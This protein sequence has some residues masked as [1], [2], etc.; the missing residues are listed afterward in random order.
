[1]ACEMIYYIKR[2]LDTGIEYTRDEH[3]AANGR[4]LH[5]EEQARFVKKGDD[6]WETG[7]I[8]RKGEPPKQGYYYDCLDKDGN[9]VRLQW[10]VCQLN[11]KKR[12]YK[13]AMHWEYFGTV[14]DG[15]RYD[16]DSGTYSKW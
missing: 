12:Y 5:P 16:P 15:I 6:Y 11:A 9:E 1:M 10:F 7:N 4:C 14:S 3:D 2:I 13:T 8:F